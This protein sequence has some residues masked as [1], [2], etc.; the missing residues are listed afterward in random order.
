M[1]ENTAGQAS[2]GTQTPAFQRTIMQDP[3]SRRRANWDKSHGAGRQGQRGILS[4]ISGEVMP[5]STLHT[6]ILQLLIF[7]APPQM[8]INDLSKVLYALIV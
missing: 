6:E 3:V 4:T 5:K 2:S 1:P 7:N 8:C